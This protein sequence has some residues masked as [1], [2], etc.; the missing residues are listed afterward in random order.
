[1]L[2]TKYIWLFLSCGLFSTAA[3]A[4][5]AR[6]AVA[7]NFAAPLAKIAAAFTKETGHKLIS[8]SGST[9]KFYAQIK[10]GAPFDI[11]LSADQDHPQK[12]A[13]ENLAFT[14]TQ[15]TYAIGKLVLW[16]PKEKFIDAK[17]SVLKANSFTHLSIA[18]PKL[19]PYGAAAR[20]ALEKMGRWRALEPKIVFGESI[21]QAY[22]FVATGNAELGF[23]A[24]SQI[25]DLK[26]IKGS[27]WMIPQELY[28]PLKQDAILLKKGENNAAAKQFLTFLKSKAAKAI[29]VEFGYGE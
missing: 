14:N 12:L 25:Q 9:G 11:L 22:Q 23:V 7:A 10:E 17:G 4:D 26:G 2:K 1:M 5:E 28:S 8:S 16:S 24:F 29:I 15:F 6:I 19:A 21:A 27:Y 18:N 3:W 20:E 13:N